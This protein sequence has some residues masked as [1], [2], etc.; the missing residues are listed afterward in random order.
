[1]RMEGSDGGC[2]CAASSGT[3]AGIVQRSAPVGPSKE[4]NLSLA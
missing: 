3:A 2:V 4:L 1:M